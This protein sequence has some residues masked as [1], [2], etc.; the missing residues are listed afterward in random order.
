MERIE[1]RYD[2]LFQE[3]AKD[4]Y[5]SFTIFEYFILEKSISKKKVNVVLRIDVDCNLYFAYLTAKYLKEK[6][7]TASFY[8]LP[9]TEQ[10]NIWENQIVNEIFQMGFE[11][12]I[13]SDHYSRQIRLGI[14][15]ISAIKE[16]VAKF[17][18]L[19]GKPP[20]GMVFHVG[21]DD[22]ENWHLY[23]YLEPQSLGLKYHDGFTSNYHNN[24]FNQF[25][26]HTDY[27]ISDYYI[28]P[29]G[30]KL[31]PF[32]PKAM[33]K[34]AREGETIHIT[35]HP[36]NMFK[37][38]KIWRV[39]YG[40]EKLPKEDFI[41]LLGK[42]SS[43]FGVKG[44]INLFLFTTLLLLV[45][46]LQLIGK[47]FFRAT[48][49]E[50][51]AFNEQSTYI[52]ER[53]FIFRKDIRFWEEKVK[54]FGWVAGRKILDFG[55]GMGQ[56]MIAL[57]HHNKEIVGIDPSFKSLMLAQGA[58]NKNRIHNSRLIKG[59]GEQLPFKNN[60]F[61]GL[62]TYGVLM[63]TCEFTAFNE[64]VRVLKNG[65]R[66]FLAVDGAG[67][68]LKNIVDGIKFSHP[69]SIKL[70]LVALANTIIGK[71]ILKRENN[72]ASFF[73]YSEIKKLFKR[74][75]FKL[76]HISPE[77]LTEDGPY[78]YLGFP[79]FFK[80]IGEKLEQGH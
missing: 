1:K 51:A 64:I 79:F 58:L 52:A 25:Y 3:L 12:G 42:L 36:T 6:N 27:S 19:I 33:L 49:E 46:F 62:F 17:S 69:E 77:A 8:F 68:F 38:W 30:W 16:D 18:T 32:M 65:G 11:I 80:A 5:K 2:R 4:R 71:Y 50:K 66:L 9:S 53:D 54:E 43:K 39:E 41:T 14:D 56:W 57:A 13:H 61:D 31:R 73:T 60:I 20:E 48:D 63:Y 70:G 76:V 40:K 55:C 67:Y 47:I 24:A 59:M 23:K 15:G 75:G 44:V 28:I 26:P 21:E 10:Y 29:N 78:D 37:W 34:R 22:V 45:G 35:I 7:I 74:Y 72:L